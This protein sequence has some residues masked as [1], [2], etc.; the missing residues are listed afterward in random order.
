MDS[1]QEI[2][3][4]QLANPDIYAMVYGLDDVAPTQADQSQADSP[5]DQTQVDP[6]P[7]QVDPSPSQ[8]DSVGIPDSQPSFLIVPALDDD[9]KAQIEYIYNTAKC[10]RDSAIS[11]AQWSV[12]VLDD[13]TTR[14][15][16]VRDLFPLI[17]NVVRRQLSVSIIHQIFLYA[18][19][20]T[21]CLS[22]QSFPR[23][24]DVKCHLL[25]VQAKVESDLANLSYRLEETFQKARKTR[26]F[27][28]QIYRSKIAN[29]RASSM[30]L[31][32]CLLPCCATAV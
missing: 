19:E 32:P 4:N 16:D 15:D 30:P 7:S 26:N 28:T 13:S 11:W 17:D 9:D 24:F 8:A 6:S 1:S 14:A 3:P 29:I 27:L 22:F 31:T 5:P 12:A 23:G 21:E 25:S 10:A 18:K 2:P 20:Q